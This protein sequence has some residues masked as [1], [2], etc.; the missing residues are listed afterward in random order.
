MPASKYRP[1]DIP[2]TKQA[3]RE[4]L[5]E[6]EKEISMEAVVFEE[7][8][9]EEEEIADEEKEVLEGIDYVPKE[10]EDEKAYANT[11]WSQS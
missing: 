9:E 4:A 6:C 1:N 8:M 5:A 7:L 11:L 3:M 2:A 10:R